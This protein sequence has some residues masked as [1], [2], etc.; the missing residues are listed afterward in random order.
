MLSLRLTSSVY[1]YLEVNQK[2]LNNYDNIVIDTN[3][4]SKNIKFTLIKNKYNVLNTYY[5]A[6]TFEDWG[7]DAMVN[8]ILDK[9]ILTFLQE[10]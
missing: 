2:T 6:Q 7:L 9:K 5:G 1:N 8:L 3:D 4:F 10:E